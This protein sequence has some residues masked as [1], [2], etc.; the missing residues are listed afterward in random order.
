[1]SEYVTYGDLPSNIKGK[2]FKSIFE[3]N[4]ITATSLKYVFKYHNITQKYFENKY[5]SLKISTFLSR[6]IDEHNGQVDNFSSYIVDVIEGL[7]AYKWSRLTETLKLEYDTLK[8]FNITLSETASDVLDTQKD[9]TTYT[10]NENLYGFNSSTAVP[11]DKNDGESN[12]E[13]KRTID[14]TRNY[15]RIGNIGNTSLQDL[16][17]Q[18]RDVA[19]F[20][21]GEILLKDISTVL[22]RGKY[23]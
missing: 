16:V 15:T 6:L 7:F 17:K 21:L 9:K 12:R 14:N 23:I 18:E 22:C 4:N 3:G 11:S 1:M 5:Y 2:I 19:N 20:N 13:Y 10:D 8:P